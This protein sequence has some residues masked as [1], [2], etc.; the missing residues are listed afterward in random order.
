MTLYLCYYLSLDD[1]INRENLA[2]KLD[3]FF[4]GKSFLALPLKEVEEFVNQI[5][6]KEGIVLNPILK[7]NLFSSYICIENNIPLIISGKPGMGKNLCLNILFDN[8]KGENSEKYFFKKKRK[9]YRYCYHGNKMK[10]EEIIEIFNATNSIVRRDEKKNINLIFIEDIDLFEKSNNNPLQIIKLCLE[11]NSNNSL[12]FMGT[13]NFRISPIKINFSLNLSNVDFDIQDLENIAISIATG[14]DHSLSY[15]FEDF[16]KV[17]AKTY[18]EYIKYEKDSILEYKDFHN[19][20]DFYYSI[21][22]AMKELI[23]RKKE[24]N[25]INEN[26]KKILTEIGIQSLIRNFSGLELINFKILDIFQ[27]LYLNNFDYS[28]N[29][30]K[31]FSVLNAI[32]KNITDPDSRYLMLITEDDIEINI[33]KYFIRKLN[34]KCIELI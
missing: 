32:E 16:F 10:T 1:K 34:K 6:I 7:E 11:N 31:S 13:L 21:K 26:N 3:V 33:V 14:L 22:T 17:M 23:E 2:K 30:N 29:I 19:N 18:Q 27:D 12:S 9:L 28:F 4:E 15:K 25:N 5:S 24:L 8:L 20:I